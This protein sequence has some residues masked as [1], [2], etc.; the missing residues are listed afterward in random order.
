MLT[1]SHLLGS[2]VI[3]F[4]SLFSF[5]D[6]LPELAWESSRIQLELEMLVALV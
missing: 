2:E 4:G 6:G 3:P 1:V 5:C